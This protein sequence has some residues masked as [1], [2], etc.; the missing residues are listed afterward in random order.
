MRRAAALA[1]AVGFIGGAVSGAMPGSAGFQPAN[2]ARP[3]AAPPSA[4]G[5]MPARPG[6]FQPAVASSG[7]SVP[8]L[9]VFAGIRRDFEEF[10][11]LAGGRECDVVAGGPAWMLATA[12]ACF[13]HVKNGSQSIVVMTVAPE[14]VP[15]PAR[16]ALVRVWCTILANLNVET[17][18]RTPDGQERHFRSIT[19]DEEDEDRG[20]NEGLENRVAPGTALGPTA[21]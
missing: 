2:A 10:L 8:D 19:D 9:P 20:G 4:A 14:D 18:A 13:A 11:H 12:P 1:I 21:P 17:P 6:G 15:A 7:P 16:A 3:E 5:K